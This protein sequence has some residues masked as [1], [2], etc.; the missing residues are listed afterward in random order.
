M[1]GGLQS[2]VFVN[3]A[4]TFLDLWDHIGVNRLNA[5][6]WRMERYLEE[7]PEITSS[8]CQTDSETRMDPLGPF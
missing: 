3:S 6:Y 4:L 2:S 7:I 5:V 1:L 8:N